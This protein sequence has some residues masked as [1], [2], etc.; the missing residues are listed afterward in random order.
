MKISFG[1][2]TTA[3]RF[4]ES[5]QRPD[6]NGAELRKLG[7]YILETMARGIFGPVQSTMRNYREKYVYRE[8]WNYLMGL[9]QLYESIN[10]II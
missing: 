6:G 5:W 4:C 7:A 3:S 2:Y 8:R 1:V 10:Y 9:S